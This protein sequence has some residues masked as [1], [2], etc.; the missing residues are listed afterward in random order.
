M[1][2]I[3]V[4]FSRSSNPSKYIIKHFLS[5]FFN[6]YYPRVP[7]V[8]FTAK[9]SEIVSFC[10]KYFLF[11]KLV[12][13]TTFFHEDV[14]ISSIIFSQPLREK[15]ENFQKNRKSFCTFIVTL[16]TAMFLFIFLQC[17]NILVCI[18]VVEVSSTHT[19]IHTLLDLTWARES[20]EKKYQFNNLKCIPGSMSIL[21][22]KDVIHKNLSMEKVNFKVINIVRKLLFSSLNLC[23][24]VMQIRCK[25]YKI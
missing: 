11:F 24:L 2:N 17:S 14:K 20:P 22:L 16:L 18:L 10:Y 9:A 21:N 12:S 25:F 19:Q 6:K 5:Q 4:F 8:Q 3:L 7:T 23:N 13:K 15:Q 1:F